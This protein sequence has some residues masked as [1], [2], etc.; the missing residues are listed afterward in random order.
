VFIVLRLPFSSAFVGALVVVMFY[1]I[2]NKI[3]VFNRMRREIINRKIKNPTEFKTIMHK[4]L[5]QTLIRNV[6]LFIIF[7]SISII[8]I[9]VPHA[10][11][12]TFGLTLIIGSIISSI[13]IY[14][15]FP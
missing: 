11:N 10:T 2:F 7:F 14:L 12:I 6:I 15:V 5:G 4:A 8:T 13:S 3:L 9:A 1:S